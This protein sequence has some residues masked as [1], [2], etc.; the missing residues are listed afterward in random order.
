MTAAVGSPDLPQS[1]FD[2][3]DLLTVSDSK[4]ILGF[5]KNARPEVLYE[6]LVPEEQGL[7]RDVFL[8]G[9]YLVTPGY[10]RFVEGVLPG[11]FVTI[12]ELGGPDFEQSEYYRQYF[13]RLQ[14]ADL[15]IFLIWVA[16]DKLI[17]VDFSRRDVNSPFSADEI[18]RF[19]LVN[20]VIQSVVKQ[21]WSAWARQ[22]EVPSEVTVHE[23]IV[24]RFESFGSEHLTQREC[25]VVRLIL[26]GHSSKSMARVLGISPGTASVHR[27]NI[28]RKLNVNSQGDLFA[29]FIDYMMNPCSPVAC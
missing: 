5:R 17:M 4:N 12:R 11:G 14:I 18:D 10:D 26:K 20:P 19:H 3:I 22:R 23:T 24:R 16:R 21:H 9:I 6:R 7:F 2:A 15:G 13:S 25:E 28:Y 8:A 1:I 29:R 27:T